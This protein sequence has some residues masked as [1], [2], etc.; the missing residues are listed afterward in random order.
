MCVC[1]CVSHVQTHVSKYVSTERLHTEQEQWQ[2]EVSSLSTQAQDILQWPYNRHKVEVS[3]P[4]HT[5]THTRTHTLYLAAAQHDSTGYVYPVFPACVC[6]SV[7]A[8]AGAASRGAH[9]TD[10]PQ[11]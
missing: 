5:H 6:E 9:N 2:A 3:R 8:R 1:V 7:H 4:T 11:N 10:E